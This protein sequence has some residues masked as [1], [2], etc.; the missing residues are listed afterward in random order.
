MWLKMVQH[1]FTE[2]SHSFPAQQKEATNGL[3]PT[4]NVVHLQKG[5]NVFS[6]SKFIKK[7]GL[8]LFY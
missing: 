5:S 8:K 7:G 3:C 4:G 2:Y 6:N 1:L